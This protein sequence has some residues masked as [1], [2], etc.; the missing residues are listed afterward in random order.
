MNGLVNVLS[1]RAWLA[2]TSSLL[3]VGACR[4]LSAN[5]RADLYDCEGCEAATERAPG[6]LTWDVDI[7]RGTLGEPLIL[8]GTIV[9]PDGRTRASGVVIYMHQTNAQGLYANGSPETVWSRRHG[10]LRGWA[11]TDAKGRYRFA[12]IKPAPYPDMTLPA[13]IHLYISE[14]GRRPYYVDDV[15][16]DGEHKVDA[17]YRARQQLRGGS[18]IVRLARSDDG[19]SLRATRNITLERHP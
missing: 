7:A 1:R 9:Q 8:D 15:V 19:K 5:A 10:R 11:L 17:A 16:F 4:A 3:M 2:G 13:H 12:T 18:G 14:P 6:N